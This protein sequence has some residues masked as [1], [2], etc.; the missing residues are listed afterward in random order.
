MTFP[1]SPRRASCPADHR[2]TGI[3]AGRYVGDAPPPAPPPDPCAVLLKCAA[4]GAAVRARR[5][6]SERASERQVERES[7]SKRESGSERETE[8]EMETARERG[9]SGR[10]MAA[11]TQFLQ[12]RIG[13]IKN[14]DNQCVHPSAVCLSPATRVPSPHSERLAL[15]RA[16]RSSDR[17]TEHEMEAGEREIKRETTLPHGTLGTQ[18][19]QLRKRLRLHANLLFGC[20]SKALW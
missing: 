17:G 16:E 19:T 13:R 2:R 9:Q 5:A 1:A 8:T 4:R 12:V 7:K 20:G 18:G 10:E 15:S 3:C 11:R 14:R 6:K